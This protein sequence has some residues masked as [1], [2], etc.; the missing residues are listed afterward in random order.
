MLVGRNEEIARIEGLIARARE[1]AGVALVVR[2]EPGIGKTCLLACAR[3]RARGMQTLSA[4]AVESESE[5]P[6]ATL[7]LLLQPVLAR[8]TE[9]TSHQRSA[10]EGALGLAPPGASDRFA[11][12]AATLAL[13]AEAAE[14]SGPLLLVV[15]DAHWLDTGSARALSFVARRLGADPI[16]L[17][18]AARAPHPLI[19]DTTGLP[20]L[21]L[22]GVDPEAAAALLEAHAGCAVDPDVAEAA[23]QATG[24]NPLALVEL[25]ELLSEEQLTG[26]EPLRHPL[27]VGHNVQAALRRRIEGLPVRTRQALVVAASCDS[28]D[29]CELSDALRAAG[30]A[31]A[32]L[33]PAEVADVVHLRADHVEFRRPLLRSTAYHAASPAERR[34]AHRALAEALRDQAPA[35]RAWHLAAAT[36]GPDE[37]VASEIERVAHENRAR[38]APMAAARAFLEAARL[39]PDRAGRSR[40][41]LE[42]VRALDAGGFP[43]RAL[44][45]LEQELS[46]EP[47][48]RVRAKLQHLRARIE[49]LRGS[50]VATH[51]LLLREAA[52]VDDVDPAQATT[53]L[54]DAGFASII[55]GQPREALRL[56]R[57]AFP[58]AQQAGGQLRLVGCL[59]MGS[60]L[61]LSGQRCGGAALLAEAEPLVDEPAM[62]TEPLITAGIP[63]HELWAEEHER[64]HKLLLRVVARARDEG[65]MNVLPYALAALSEA[66]F[67]LGNWADAYAS[68][69]QSV[70]LAEEVGQASELTHSLVRLAA[71][72]AGQ[73][74]EADCRAHIRR[75]L[76]L[77]GSLGIGSIRTLA[78]CVVGQLELGLG[79][80][81]EAAEQ[82]EAAGRLAREGGLLQP[83]VAPWAENLAEAYVRE[84][85]PGKAEAVVGELELRARAADSRG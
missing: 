69:S 54:L 65:A 78:H 23:H 67:R 21:T 83:S 37:E 51:D 12:Y 44:E 32:D 38:A 39:T 49:L 30:L 10:L 72:E 71:V 64:G 50:P 19:F 58:R 76:D 77:A 7:S 2:G 82:L 70:A 26:R 53:M 42:A 33:E 31:E 81:A 43:E 47:E 61:L 5:L 84:G 18:V 27:P 75:A 45:L 56:A 35:A 48:P 3:E 4:R 34:A 25:A 63:H 1:G 36:L 41:R 85:C 24:G 80:H 74:R 52:H 62:R 9:L 59:L 79:H 29:M 46:R 11:V 16:A 60:A 8:R 57:Q 40:R 6:Y 15:D 28:P 66:E 55:S 20:E 73:G 14:G 17:L 68:A 22:T 13:L